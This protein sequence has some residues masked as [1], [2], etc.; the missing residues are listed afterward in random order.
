VSQKHI[1]SFLLN[2]GGR[3][4]TSMNYVSFCCLSIKKTDFCILFV[5]IV[6]F[7]VLIVDLDV[8]FLFWAILY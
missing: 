2:K 4:V 6:S 8:V 5:Q 7:F 3:A 1:F